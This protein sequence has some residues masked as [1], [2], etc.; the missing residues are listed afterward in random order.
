MDISSISSEEIQENIKLF[1]ADY[2]YLC[3]TSSFLSLQDS[4]SR[5]AL[6]SSP[7]HNPVEYRLCS[8]ISFQF[9]AA[10]LLGVAGSGGKKRK[11]LP[12]KHVKHWKRSSIKPHRIPLGGGAESSLQREQTFGL[13]RTN[14]AHSPVSK[15]IL[16]NIVWL[17]HS[18]NRPVTATIPSRPLF[19]EPCFTPQ[20]PPLL[21]ILNPNDLYWLTQSP[22]R[23]VLAFW[24][25]R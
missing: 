3:K 24:T 23:Q 7:S 9:W 22:S 16:C 11:F 21:D 1:H 6:C 20:M 2:F 19:V 13:I 18:E 10:S 12:P 4:P 15:L 14:Q 17:S 25:R 5:W 8:Q